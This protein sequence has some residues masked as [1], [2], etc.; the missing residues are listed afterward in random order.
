MQKKNLSTPSIPR[1]TFLMHLA[2]LQ[3]V[4]KEMFTFTEGMNE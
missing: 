2:F 3:N 4:S 1:T